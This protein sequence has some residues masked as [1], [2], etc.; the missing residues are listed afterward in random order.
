MLSKLDKI[1]H[2][3]ICNAGRTFARAYGRNHEK[4]WLSEELQVE[5]C[6]TERNLGGRTFQVL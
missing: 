4:Y 2:S 6:P 1:K 5:K 3:S